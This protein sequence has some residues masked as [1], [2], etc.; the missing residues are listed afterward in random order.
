[1]A[2]RGIENSDSDE[3]FATVAQQDALI[4]HFG[5]GRLLRALKADIQH[6]RVRVIIDPKSPGGC[7]NPRI[8]WRDRKT[9]FT[10]RCAYL[11]PLP[12]QVHVDGQNRVAFEELFEPPHAWLSP[13]A[14]GGPLKELRYRHHG[15]RQ[16]AIQEM[17]SV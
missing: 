1:M 7:R 6:V 17:R 14:D 15:N 9:N 4:G 16:F 13:I 12:T 8:L 5:V 11:G 10:S 3:V 2:C